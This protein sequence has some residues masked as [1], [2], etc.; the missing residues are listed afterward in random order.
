MHLSDRAGH[1]CPAR[2]L[3]VFAQD[4]KFFA[5]PNFVTP[6]AGEGPPR[7][8][9][10]DVSQK[11]AEGKAQRDAEENTKHRVLKL[12]KPRPRLTD[13]LPTASVHAKPSIMFA[14]TSAVSVWPIAL[15]AVLHSNT[16][17]LTGNLL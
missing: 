9:R 1:R 17:I 12:P 3:G 11:C 13:R 7:T 10:S 8:S 15:R 2:K 5:C 6:A 14:V 16:S 4:P